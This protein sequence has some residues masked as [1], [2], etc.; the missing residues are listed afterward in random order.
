MR[1]IFDKQPLGIEDIEIGK[2]HVKQIRNGEE[3]E[4]EPINALY[5]AGLLKDLDRDAIPAGVEYLWFKGFYEEG[6]DGQG[7]Y[8]LV[9]EDAYY[10]SEREDDVGLYIKANGRLYEREGSWNKY[11][12]SSIEVL[13]GE[14]RHYIMF[15]WYG[16][17]PND[18]S[19][20][21]FW[22]LEHAYRTIYVKT[23]ELKASQHYYFKQ[24]TDITISRT[25]SLEIRG[26]NAYMHFDIFAGAFHWEIP[27]IL[28]YIIMRD[29][30]Y[31]SIVPQF[32]FDGN[33]CRY[34]NIYHNSNIQQPIGKGYVYKKDDQ[35]IVGSINVTSLPKI[36]KIHKAYNAVVNKKYVDEIYKLPDNL[37]TFDKEEREA[38]ITDDNKYNI[39]G[40]K[41][42]VITL[43]RDTEFDDL[44]DNDIITKEEL[45]KWLLEHV[46][47]LLPESEFRIVT[48]PAGFEYL[49]FKVH[50]K[51]FTI[52]TQTFI[53][54]Q[55][56]DLVWGN[57]YNYNYILDDIEK[58]KYTCS[59]YENNLGWTCTYINKEGESVEYFKDATFDSE[60]VEYLDEEEPATLLGGY[61][62]V[63]K[64]VYD[65]RY[66][67]KL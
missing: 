66:W 18:S 12:D 38:E 10:Y 54:Y 65:I 64:E 8:A 15:E 46:D 44:E 23:I 17:R 48:V 29:I 33:K 53:V 35:E 4:L 60:V 42:T 9:P 36:S 32:S 34:F 45:A 58:Y 50:I 47:E 30:N 39:S 6:D 41:Q 57:I 61:W 26:N 13:R 56:A 20:N 3:V 11:P 5:D 1:K 16:A 21:C 19:Y 2:E 67:E 40:Y 28:E 37:A 25:S 14:K 62:R 51:K 59:L 7:I 22:I 31:A 63:N 52:D 43:E 27:T 55:G 49:Q 24:Y